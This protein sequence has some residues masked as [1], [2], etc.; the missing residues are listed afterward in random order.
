MFNNVDPQGNPT[1]PITNQLVNFGWEYVY[2]C[3]ILSHE[4]MDMM[5]PVSL[6]LPPIKPDG[7]DV[8][9]STGTAQHRRVTLT[10]NDNSI[11]ET[12]FVVQRTTNGT[13]WT[14]V[15]NLPSRWVTANTHGTRTL[16]RP[17]VQRDD[18]VQVPGRRPEHRRLRL[19]DAVHDGVVD[20][21]PH[22]RQRADGSDQPDGDAGVGQAAPLRG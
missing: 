15:G 11:T 6:A 14:D 13:T 4:E 10:W 21:R 12:S 9:S 2:H 7:L 22:R 20:V 18:C 1:T 3:H 8:T 17:H 19:G 5:R 16:H